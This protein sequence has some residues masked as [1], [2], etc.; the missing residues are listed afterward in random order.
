MYK[1]VSTDPET[2]KQIILNPWF[3]LVS[4]VQEL[5]HTALYMLRSFWIAHSLLC[6]L[7]ECAG[8]IWIP[9]RKP[10][11]AR[12]YYSALPSMIWINGR[13][14]MSFQHGLSWIEG[15]AVTLPVVPNDIFDYHW[16]WYI[17]QNLHNYKA[18]DFSHL[19]PIWIGTTLSDTRSPCHA[20]IQPTGLIIG[21]N[22]GVLVLMI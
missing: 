2:Q 11:I 12:L 17:F 15:D 8:I 13:T 10:W 5:L 7:R 1:V 4:D 9:G 18:L 20:S 19:I 22:G 21:L 14:V 6:C 3:F 16:V